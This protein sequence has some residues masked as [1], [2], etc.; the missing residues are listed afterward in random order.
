MTTTPQSEGLKLHHEQRHRRDLLLRAIC[1]CR[2]RCSIVGAIH[3][4]S[5][6]GYGNYYFT[7]DANDLPHIDDELYE[8]LRK[9]VE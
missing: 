7:L 9:A 1:G 6:H 5:I 3:A 2:G 4:V 8:A